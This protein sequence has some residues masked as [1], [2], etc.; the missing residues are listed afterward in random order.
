MSLLGDRLAMVALP[1]LVYRSTGSALST[2]LVFALYTL[3]YVLFGAF[4]G[5]LIDRLDKRLVM[6]ASDVARTGLV[7]L[8]PLAATVSLPAVYVLS[9]LIASAAVFFDP[10]KLAILPDLVSRDKLMRANSL[11]ATGENVTEILGYAARGIHARV[12]LHDQRVP[13]RRGHLCGVGRVARPDPLQSAGARPRPRRWPARSA[14]NCA[15]GGTSSHST[16]ACV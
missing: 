15:R 9:F 7:I 12:H 16:A 1:W 5:V 6:I 8:V 13:H 11:L 3:P 4:A 10:C 14:E 2:G